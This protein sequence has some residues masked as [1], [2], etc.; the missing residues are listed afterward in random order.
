MS[1]TNTDLGFEVDPELRKRIEDLAR[2]VRELNE[3]IER[4][5]KEFEEARKRIEEMVRGGRRGG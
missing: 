1:S 3:R 4:A 5:R 2:S